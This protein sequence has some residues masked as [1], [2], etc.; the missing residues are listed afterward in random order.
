MDFITALLLGLVQGL[1]EF[2]PISSSGHLVMAQEVL[3]VEEGGVLFEVALHVG[4][5]AAVLWFYRKR[6]ASLIAGALRRDVGVWV[7][8]AKLGVATLPAGVAV[9]LFRDFLEG[10]FARPWVAG[11]AL[12]V[13]AALLWTTRRTLPCANLAEPGWLAALLIGCAQAAA[14]VPGI[15]RSGATVAAGLALGVRSESAAEFSFLMSVAAI[16]GA[17]ALSIGGLGAVDGRTQATLGLGVLVALVSGVLALTLFV[18]LLRTGA[19]HRFAY[20]DVL[21]GGLF[22]AWLALR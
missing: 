7:Y 12:L 17:A 16:G 6:I 9:L 19:F 10:L 21:A 11:V 13:T 14:I 1:S 8:I 18:R 2:L 4:T 22:L 3:G 15:S 5:L 20:Y